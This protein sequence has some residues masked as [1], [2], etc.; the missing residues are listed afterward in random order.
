[1]LACLRR[2]AVAIP[3]RYASAIMAEVLFVSKPIAPPWNDS[4]K[5]LVHALARSLRRPPPTLMVGAQAALVRGARSARV[6]GASVGFAPALLDQARVF[7]H[8]IAARR[9][10]L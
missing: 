8:L 3:P 6:Y 2:L 9:H 5:N 4:G 1:M 10:A 7:A